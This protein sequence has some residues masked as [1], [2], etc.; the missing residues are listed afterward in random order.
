MDKGINYKHN[1]P[2][3]KG[4]VVY[5]HPP[6]GSC[7]GLGSPSGSKGPAGPAKGDLGPLSLF[8]MGLLI[9]IYNFLELL[10]AIF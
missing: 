3:E 4:R 2:N 10:G 6:S 8:L 5:G 9:C 1:F 7:R